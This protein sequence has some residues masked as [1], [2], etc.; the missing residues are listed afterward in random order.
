MRK[1]YNEIS[2]PIVARELCTKTE[3]QEVVEENHIQKKNEMAI[4]TGEKNV[5]KISKTFVQKTQRDRI[6]C[7]TKSEKIMTMIVF[8]G[9]R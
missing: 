1:K 8:Y 3:E 7:D 5:Y 6:H 9:L 4:E 2:I